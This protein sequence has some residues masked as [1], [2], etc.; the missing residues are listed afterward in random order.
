VSAS[1][2]RPSEPRWQDR[3]P[4]GPA[5]ASA[6]AAARGHAIRAGAPS[7]SQAS[8]PAADDVASPRRPR[9]RL[10]LVLPAAAALAVVVAV[11]VRRYG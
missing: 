3:L 8:P 7:R 4:P 1:S 11:L 5:A 6:E 10:R 9:A 2:S